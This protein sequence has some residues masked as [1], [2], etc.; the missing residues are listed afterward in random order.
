MN[1]YAKKTQLLISKYDISY[2]IYNFN[3]FES[4]SKPN[5]IDKNVF[6]SKYEELDLEW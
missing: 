5:A 6:C 4:H 2:I 1:T 3:S